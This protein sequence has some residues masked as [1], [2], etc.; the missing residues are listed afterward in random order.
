MKT[1]QLISTMEI[2]VLVHDAVIIYKTR[3]MLLLTSNLHVAKYKI[4][5]VIFMESRRYSALPIRELNAFRN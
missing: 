2:L 3:T 5:A 1:K 4:L